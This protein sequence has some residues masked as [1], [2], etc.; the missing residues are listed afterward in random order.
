VGDEPGKEDGAEDERRRGEP[1]SEDVDQAGLIHVSSDLCSDVLAG[2]LV[3]LIRAA[4]FRVVLDELC[5]TPRCRSSETLGGTRVEF[6]DTAKNSLP[7]RS[8]NVGA[9]LRCVMRPTDRDH[10]A[11]TS[12]NLG[13]SR[14]PGWPGGSSGVQDDHPSMRTWPL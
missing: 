5:G 7:A 1:E 2:L 8:G 14:L 3:W 12:A 11:I 10:P 6:M 13:H 4:F 9:P